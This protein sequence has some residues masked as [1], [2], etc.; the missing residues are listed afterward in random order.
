MIILGFLIHRYCKK[1]ETMK[2]QKSSQ[3]LQQ[4]RN[5]VALSLLFG[6]GWALGLPATEGIDNVAVRTTFQVLFIIV[7]AFQGLYIFIIQCLTGSNAV[8][9][10]KEWQRWFALITFHPSH[11]RSYTVGQASSKEMDGKGKVSVQTDTLMSLKTLP[12]STVEPSDIIDQWH[13]TALE[14][15]LHQEKKVNIFSKA[16]YII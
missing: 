15:E 1:L 13:T 2:Q 6:I 3:I 16:L 4:F 5:A 8:E 14:I 10:K 7:T 11:V 9:A 12:S